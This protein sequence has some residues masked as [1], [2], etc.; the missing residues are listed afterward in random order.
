[1]SYQV[2]VEPPHLLEAAAVCRPDGTA[3]VVPLG[4]RARG[5]VG[6]PHGGDGT[7]SSGRRPAPGAG[8]PGRVVR[9]LKRR[10]GDATPLLVG[11]EAGGR[12]GAGCAVPRPAARR[13]GAAR[14]RPRPGV[15]VTHP[16]AGART[17][18]SRCGR[19][20]ATRASGR[21]RWCPSPRPRPSRTHGGAGAAGRDGRR[22][23]PGRRP[24]R[25]VGRARWPRRVDGGG[26]VPG[27]GFGGADLDEV[28]FGHVREALGP[29]WEALDPADPEVLA[30][31]AE[32]RRECTA[33]KEAL[34]RDTEVLVPVVLP[35]AGRR[36]GSGARSSRR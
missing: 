19:R 28:V 6:R 17:G 3:Q 27:L 23:R 7:S 26:H 14:G 11:R 31:V 12:R 24:V 25:G 16:A 5:G 36:C 10:V 22:V 18:S 34:S 20:S 15:A 8:R 4:D 35:G 32:L 29:A 9:E 33:A 30:A 1:M 2:G 13:R 21:R